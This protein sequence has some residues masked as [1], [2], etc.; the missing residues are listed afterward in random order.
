MGLGSRGEVVEE[1]KILS[2][3]KKTFWKKER[4]AQAG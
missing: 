4:H 2:S 1:K 3:G